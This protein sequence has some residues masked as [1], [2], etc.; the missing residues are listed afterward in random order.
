MPVCAACKNTKTDDRCSNNSLRGV[1]FCG[2]HARMKN[3]R[4]WAKINGYDS[5]VTKIQ[6]LWRG[7]LIR[8]RLEL[9]GPGVLKRSLCNNEDE[10]ITFESI[11][12]VHPLDYFGFEENGKVYGFDIRSIVD[13]LHRTATNPF[14]RQNLTIDCRIRIRQI[15]G[16]RLR[17][18][19][20]NYYEHN[21]LKSPTALVQNRWIQVC[22]IIE[23]NGFFNVHPNIFLA[24]N[25]SQLYIFLNMISNDLQ[26][27]AAEHKSSASRRYKYLTW[28]KSAILKFYGRVEAVPYYSFNVATTLS[29]LLYDCVDSYNICFIIMSALYRL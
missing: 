9:A 23:E 26:V 10:L 19:L 21:T 18:K 27:W 2:V 24:L 16:Y 15:Y 14:T 8:K 22:Q 6:K 17:H 5:K 1:I 12:S 29:V 25:K 28:I 7:Y 13:S 20:Q 3:P 11:R 4:I